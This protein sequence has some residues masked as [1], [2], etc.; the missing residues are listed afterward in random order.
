MTKA[1]NIIAVLTGIIALI[2]GVYGGWSHFSEQNAWAD[3]AKRE[4]MVLAKKV[5]DIDL[6]VK[7]SAAR[8]T[9][10]GVLDEL[11]FYTKQLRS[12]PESTQIAKKLK[13]LEAQAKILEQE[14]IDLRREKA[15]ND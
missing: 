3:D 7:I 11:L 2:G 13:A 8:D 15:K 5:T 9:Y 10:L 4:H 12:D 6:R 14:I 1:K